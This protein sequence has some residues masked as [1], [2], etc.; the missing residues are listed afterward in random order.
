MKNGHKNINDIASRSHSSFSITDIP[1]SAFDD[2]ADVQWASRTCDAISAQLRW[3]ASNQ[4]R[5]VACIGGNIINASPISD[6]NPVWQACG[7]VLTF[8]SMQSD[9]Q[10]QHANQTDVGR[11]GGQRGIVSSDSAK[12]N[13]RYRIVQRHVNIRDFFLDYRKVDMRD[14]EVLQSIHIP[15]CRSKDEFVFAFKQSK[16]REDDIAIVTACMRV[17]LC[18]VIPTPSG[19]DNCDKNVDDNKK[20]DDNDDDDNDNDGFN[21][22]FGNQMNIDQD[23]RI[24]GHGITQGQLVD[25]ESSLPNKFIKN[26]TLSFGGMWKF[27]VCAKSSARYLCNKNWWTLQRRMTKIFSKIRQD[28]FLPPNVPG[29]M[30]E[31]RMTLASSFFFKFFLKVSAQLAQMNSNL[32]V[33]EQKV[34]KSKLT[35]HINQPSSQ[36]SV[37]KPQPSISTVSHSVSASVLPYQRGLSQGMQSYQVPRDSKTAVGKDINH[38]SAKIQ[39]SGEAKYVDDLPDMKG[40]IQ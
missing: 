27:T 36:A 8:V 39:C 7:A 3:F 9:D 31:Y 37:P 5:N 34:E 1:L 26:C 29:G 10:D 14:N 17:E 22:P 21:H 20:S 11:S 16:R 40:I 25:I 6:L 13:S 2:P 30:E 28:M 12:S 35:S 15:F 38:V 24:L 19:D 18:D 23:G 4:T 33:A 32:Q